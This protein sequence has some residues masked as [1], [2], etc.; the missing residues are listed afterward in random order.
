MERKKIEAI[1]EGVLFAAGSEVAADK[2]CE[3]LETDKPTIRALLSGMM[4]EYDYNRRGIHIIQVGD[5]YQMCTRPEYADYIGRLAEPQRAQALSAAALE[6][7]AVIA[8]RQPVTRPTIEAIRGLNCDK[9]IDKLLERGLIE[10]RGRLNAPGKPIL[11][12]VTPEFMR[13]FGIA[14]LSEL[15]DFETGGGAGDDGGLEQIVME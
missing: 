12:G 2:L 1:I 5:A 9:P 6:T 13:A 3:I 14:E 10:E 15:P 4:D 11:F 7:L 8:Y